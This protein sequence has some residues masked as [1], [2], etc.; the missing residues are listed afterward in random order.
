MKDKKDKK[1]DSRSFREAL[2]RVQQRHADVI[3][4]L[5]NK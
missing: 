5:E 1:E 4:A 2:K 3:K